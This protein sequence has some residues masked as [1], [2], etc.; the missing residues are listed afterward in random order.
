MTTPTYP[1]IDRDARARIEEALAEAAASRQRQLDE[2]SETAGD[3]PAAAHRASVAR[4]LNDVEAA[5]NRLARG[6]FGACERCATAIPVERLEL[7]PWTRL[8]VGCASR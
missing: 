8:C 2:L 6:T 7:R 1:A 3:S 4:I 5:Q